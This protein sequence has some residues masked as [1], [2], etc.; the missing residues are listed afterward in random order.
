MIENWK[1]SAI[2]FNNMIINDA[3]KE[4]NASSAIAYGLDG[5]DEAVQQD[6]EA[7]RG[8]LDSNSFIVGLK[9]DSQRIQLIADNLLASLEK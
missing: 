7:V 6:F 2:K 1:N 9:E 3:G 5:G 8:S 4:F